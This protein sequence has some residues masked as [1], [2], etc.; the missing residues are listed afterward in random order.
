[1]ILAN[2]SYCHNCEALP[3]CWSRDLYSP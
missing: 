3:Y 1:M 2:L